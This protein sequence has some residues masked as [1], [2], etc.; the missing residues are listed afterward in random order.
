MAQTNSPQEPS[1]DLRQAA[2]GLRQMFVAL[3]N[4][5]FTRS[6]ALEIVGHV[7]RSQGGGGR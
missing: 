7:L 2:N 5:G 6:E 4:E 1:A 3:V